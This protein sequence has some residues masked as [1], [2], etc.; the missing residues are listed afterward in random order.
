MQ[1]TSRKDLTDFCRR[2]E[3]VDQCCVFEGTEQCSS[4]PG[5]FADGVRAVLF[6]TGGIWINNLMIHIYMIRKMLCDS[7]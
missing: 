6:G 2:R 4:G 5:C 3:A 7:S 1:C